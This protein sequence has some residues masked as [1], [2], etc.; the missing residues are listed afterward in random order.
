MLGLCFVFALAASA[1]LALGVSGRSAQ[2]PNPATGL[3]PDGRQLEPAGT[4]VTLG[5]LPTG[6]AL[7]ADGRFLWTVSAGVGNND[8]RIVDTAQHRVCQILPVPGAT[9]GIALDS[10]HRLAYVSGLTASLWLPTQFS[11]PGAKGNDVLVFSWTNTCGQA[12][13]VGEIEVPPP[14]GTLAPQAFPPNPNGMRLSWPEMLSVSPDGSQLLVPLNLADCAAVV[15]LSQRDQVHYVALGSGSYPFGSTI[16]PGGH[17]GLVTNEGNGTMSVIDMQSA[18]VLATIRLGAE[19]SH[20]AR[21]VVDGT[22]TRAYVA[23]S[24]ADDVVVVNLRTRRVTRTISVRSRFGVGTMPV[25]VALSPSGTR[26]FVALS[27]ADALAVIRVPSKATPARGDWTTVG[28]IPTAEQ[29]EDVLTGSGQAGQ[30]ARLVWIAARGRDTGAIPKGPNP[31]DP[32]DPIFWAFHPIPPPT[33]DIFEQGTMYGAIMLRGQ[34]GLM[35][36]PSDARI[37]A[38]TPVADAEL[39]PVGAQ[40]APPNTPLRAGG[41]IKHVFFVVREN[42]SY[43]QM[44]G[45]VKRGDGDPKLLV[46]GKNVTPN[47]HSLVN[48]FPLLDNV[49]ADSDASIQGHYW[50]SAAMVP[51]YVTRNW[52]ANY[53]GR[54]RPADFGAY[55]ITRPTNGFLFDQ[56]QREHISYFNYGE[57]WSGLSVMPDRDRTPALLK[58]EKLV[59]AHSDLGP[60]ITPGGCYASDIHIGSIGPHPTDGEIF[61]SSLPA[62][63]PP[64]SNS[65]F[66]CFRNRFERQ[67]AHND[68][69]TFNYLIFNDDHTRGT[70]PGYPT[71]TAMVADDDWALGQL[72]ALI[73]HSRIWSSSA[74]FVVED[75]SQDGADHLDAHREPALVISPYARRGAVIHT[76][77]DLLSVVRSMELIMGMKPLGLND[78]LAT[79]MYNVF[80]PTP[81]NLGPVNAIRPKVNLLTRNTLASPYAPAS[82]QLPLGS[83]DLVP[84]QELDSIIWK[85]VYG[86]DSTPPPPGPNA[87]SD[88]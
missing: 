37:A 49:L 57:V 17:T 28:R 15:D 56:A 75:D 80:S 78:A 41:P 74:I 30:R 47:M 70:Q 4:L 79:P 66:T 72:V 88:Q 33:V 8:V 73:S 1:A 63:A 31:V 53:S 43:D 24:N 50:T 7:T 22:A 14:P 60:D 39:H 48:R 67:L 71:P 34:A 87:G 27:G 77:Y 83:P 32:N 44:L 55:A 65:H 3:L 46:F 11:L 29:P 82:S 10:A 6:G 42:R 45:D 84:Q 61:D 40:S 26:L 20:P 18:T 58:E 23:L 38:L 16:L 9:G 13:L 5:N 85:S 81:V 25:A 19:L 86:A 62:G 21:V 52:V 64:G 69:P 35:A 36:L 54:F 51:D 12:R 2:R 76:R 59:A 68:V